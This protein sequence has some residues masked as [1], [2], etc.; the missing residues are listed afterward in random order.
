MCV[1]VCWGC[2]RSR[3][4]MQKESHMKCQISCKIFESTFKKNIRLKD[5]GILLR[6][7]C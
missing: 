5:A 7:R 1:D 6:K 4:D 3:K 2:V